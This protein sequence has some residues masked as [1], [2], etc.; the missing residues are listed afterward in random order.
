MEAARATWTDSRLDDLSERVKGMDQK[1]DAGFE[2][3][4][5]KMDAGFERLD[6]KMDAGYKRLDQKMDAGFARL[7]EKIDTGLG[8]LD[9]RIDGLHHDLVHGMIA[10]ISIIAV[11]LTAFLTVVVTHL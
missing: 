11:L 3:L 1:M 10:L 5:Q 9:D 2:R 6:Q 8:R 4:D 7:D